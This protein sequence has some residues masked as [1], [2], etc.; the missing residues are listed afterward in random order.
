MYA[1]TL[2]SV[3]P[4]FTYELF[5][6]LYIKYIFVTATCRTKSVWIQFELV[7]QEVATKCAKTALSQHLHTRV[8]LQRLVTSCVNYDLKS[9]LLRKCKLYFFIIYWPGIFFESPVGL[10]KISCHSRST[11]FV[12]MMTDGPKKLFLI[13]EFVLLFVEVV[14]WLNENHSIYC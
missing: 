6:I 7:Q 12:C 9:Q 11:K 5:H 4:Q 14:S 8:K 2:Q 10:A 13:Y 1:I 3:H